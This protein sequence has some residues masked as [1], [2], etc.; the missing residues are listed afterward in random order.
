MSDNHP[1]R[2]SP[3]GGGGAAPRRMSRV[4][5]HLTVIL[6]VGLGVVA[7]VFQ[8]LVDLKQEK[9]GVEIN[10]T[11]LVE[12]L[13]PTASKAVYNFDERGA[14]QVA[15][16]LFTQRAIG[17]VVIWEGDS[18]Y[19]EFDRELAPTLPRLGAITGG[20]H[21]VITRNLYDPADNDR[22]AAIGR[23]Q[24]T[25]DRSIVPPAIVDRMLMYFAIAVLKNSL[26]G[27]LLV[28]VVFS[29]LARHVVRL[30][31]VV[32]DWTPTSGAIKKPEP[33]KYLHD[34]E[35]DLLGS[36]IER[37]ALTA[38]DAVRS[39]EIS[40]EKINL[41]NSELRG[42]SDNLS[43]ALSERNERLNKLNEELAE[44]ANK[45]SL[46][47]IYNRRHFEQE[48]TK[49]WQ[50]CEANKADAT[51]ALFDID[52]FKAYN[53]FYGHQQGDECLRQVAAAL[54]ELVG[55]TSGIFARYGGEE[56]IALIAD[57]GSDQVDAIAQRFVDCVSALE[58]EHARSLN[59][60]FVSI[61]VGV[62]CRDRIGGCSLQDFVGAADRALY[63][64]KA[65]GRGRFIVAS[66]DLVSS[67][68]RDE[69]ATQQILNAIRHRAFVPFYQPQIDARTGRL[70]G[71]ETLAR[72]RREDGQI[73]PPAAFLPKA[74]KLGLDASIDA[75]VHEKALE[76]LR[77][78]KRQ[79]IAPERFSMN[80]S[81]NRLLSGELHQLVD[82]FQDLGDVQLAFELLEATF[83]EQQSSV[84]AHRLD[85]LRDSGVSIEVDD[86]GTGH[87]SLVSLAMISPERIKIARE[88]IAPLGVD[89]R[90]T[91]VVE[92]V[93]EMAQAFEIDLIAE[94]V[95]TKAQS[96]MLLSLK[97]PIQQGYFY[98]RP[99][100]AADIEPMLRANSAAPRAVGG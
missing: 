42:Q 100:S 14:R 97:C 63:E 72:W 47:G 21:V 94:G 60:N 37:L 54:G 39:L 8:M 96:D 80:M 38:S 5:M 53:D 85:Q 34:T 4:L 99:A 83:I 88:L 84:F 2:P 74:E 24:V 95:E 93:V 44:I 30:A 86:F 50:T 28:I 3:T 25:V 41:A 66:E 73:L 45:D 40:N 7:G 6:T 1:P 69:Q 19:V 76:Q 32:D 26:L 61:S 98:A 58:I 15:V 78:W 31:K 77:A 27:A 23:L 11:E 71:L 67:V 62:A 36:K 91:K 48:A 17:R 12:S 64:A 43:I 49:I 70:I 46:T 9:D 65:A 29:G 82:R 81:E 18:I 16:G 10:A 35:L 87:T 75:I 33:P 20:D 51:I 92:A 68:K 89:A 90:A 56:F 59:S 57:V 22:A 52:Y 79:N 13:A 55:E